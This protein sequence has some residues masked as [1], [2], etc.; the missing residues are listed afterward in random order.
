MI[1]LR[2]PMATRTLLL[3]VMAVGALAGCDERFA[4]VSN[5]PRF[6]QNVG[7]R[8]E[9]IGA[10]DAYGIRHHSKAPVDYVTLIPPPGIAGSEVGFRI[11]I[12]P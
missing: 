6:R 10:V 7:A 11:R 8:Y 12:A 5:D 3:T 4:D 1:A 9:V 2:W